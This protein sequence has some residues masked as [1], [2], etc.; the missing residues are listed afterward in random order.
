MIEYLVAVSFELWWMV[1][2]V[3]YFLLFCDINY[4][5]SRNR[6]IEKYYAYVVK[7]LVVLKEGCCFLD[8]KYSNYRI[9]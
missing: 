1:Q 9:L 5:C 7:G 3:Q 6:D 4:C 2:Y 8:K